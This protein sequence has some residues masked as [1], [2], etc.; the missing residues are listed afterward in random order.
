MDRYFY[1]IEVD[2]EG[3][4]V[5]HLLGNIYDLEWNDTNYV[6]DEYTFLYIPIKDV[7]LMIDTDTFYEY[8]AEKVSYSDNVSKAEA[9]KVC[10]E[11]F[12]GNHGIELDIADITEGTPCGD[13]WFEGSKENE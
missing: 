12:N 11:Y 9:Y 10:N 8:I 1:S 6:I 5:V 4:K 2:T 13:Y 3:N 7:I